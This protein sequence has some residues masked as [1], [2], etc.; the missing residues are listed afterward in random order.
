[1]GAKAEC[2]QGFW[3]AVLGAYPQPNQALEP[4][5]NS[6]RCAPAVG[7]G[8]PR[9][10]GICLSSSFLLI[11]TGV[12]ALFLVESPSKEYNDVSDTWRL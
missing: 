2:G 11:N 1:M 6:V 3:M 9:A 5:A 8:S 4:T 7:G 12:F 10:F